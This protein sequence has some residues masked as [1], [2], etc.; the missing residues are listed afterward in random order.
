MKRVEILRAVAIG[1]PKAGIDDV[2]G[3]RVFGVKLTCCV[4]CAARSHLALEMEVL[5]CSLDD[6]ADG[7]VADILNVAC[8]AMSVESV[9][10]K[11]RSVVTRGS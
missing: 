10:G 1:P 8:T 9:L 11:G 4:L 5:D 2:Q 3:R 7:C 6:A